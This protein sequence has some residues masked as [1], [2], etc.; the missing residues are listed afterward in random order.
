MTPVA[1][2]SSALA[3]ALLLSTVSHAQF[4]YFSTSTAYPLSS[5]DRA[6]S[7]RG[8]A[9]GE[10]TVAIPGYNDPFAS[11]PAGIAGVHGYG[12]EYSH[13]PFF[14]SPSDDAQYRSWSATAETPIGVFACAYRRL[15][16][17]KFFFSGPTSPA[18]LAQSTVYDHTIGLAWGYALS[19]RFHVGVAAKMFN[20]KSVYDWALVPA[21][22]ADLV[23]ESSPAY[24]FDF[25]VLTNTGTLFGN[26][27]VSDN[28]SLGT[29]L[30]GFGTT[31][32]LHYSSSTPVFDPV[33]MTSS[34]QMSRVDF[35]IPLA[36]NLRIGF[37]Y[38]LTVS[39][40]SPET[41]D[42]FSIVVTGEYRDLLN[43]SMNQGGSYWGLG[44]EVSLF[45]IL[46]LRC[47][48]LAGPRD[49]VYGYENTLHGRY[50]AGL[51]LPLRQLVPTFPGV[52]I[53]ASYSMMQLV[54]LDPSM[55][56]AYSV[57]IHYLP[58]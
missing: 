16:Y 11:N 12:V 20:Q 58:D 39:S 2:C 49:L 1:R 57:G 28:L 51:R 25:G 27:N 31:F 35:T 52:V 44:M 34:V 43:A 8:M 50:G 55:I 30:Q 33:S 29:S 40:E 5:L 22:V 45:E 13:Q 24:L 7:P 14:Y 47:G 32:R 9:L 41:L 17:P 18:R 56:R 54:N 19:S 46:Q 10:A 6:I 37:A 23:P 42:P 36:R 38:Q 21:A 4:E 53:E 48:G 3:F 26:G 15:D